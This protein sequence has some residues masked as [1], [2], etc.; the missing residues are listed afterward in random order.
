M[1]GWTVRPDGS[2]NFRSRQ[3]VRDRVFFSL[4]RQIGVLPNLF[5]VWLE[6]TSM[7]ELRRWLVEG[8]EKKSTLTNCRFTTI[9]SQ[10]SAIYMN[11]FHKTEVQMV[12][13]RC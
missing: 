1:E 4:C 2:G 3:A 10:I 8:E 6:I 12:I 7:F 13:L 9:S 11:I 5:D